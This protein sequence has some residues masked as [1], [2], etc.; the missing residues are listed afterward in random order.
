MI[1]NNIIIGFFALLFLYSCV[2][3]FASTF[4]KWFL[5]IGC[6]LGILSI[7]DKSLINTIA[8]YTG[9]ES[10]RVLL[11]YL[12]FI[13]IF[14]FVFYTYEKFSKLDKRI[15]KLTSDLAI[16]NAVRRKEDI[17]NEDQSL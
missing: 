14:L 5:R 11:L 6:I 13:T 4:A 7:S 1:L 2:R 8:N 10:G 16:T 12:S 3:P 15:S 9:V 17:I